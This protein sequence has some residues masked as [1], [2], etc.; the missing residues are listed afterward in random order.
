VPSLLEPNP[1]GQ[2]LEQLRTSGAPLLDLTEMNPTR[3]GL[4]DHAAVADVLRQV[5]EDPRATRY[6]PDPRGLPSARR[7][8]AEY[9]G[10]AVDS[11]RI[12][13]TT[14]TS[15]SYAHLFRLLADPG[16]TV[17]IP[18]PSYPLFDPIAAAEG[19][20]TASYRLE[21]QDGDWAPNVRSIEEACARHDP[22]AL[23][24]VQPNI[25]TGSALSASALHSLD[26]LG[27]ERGLA[28][29]SDEVFADFPWPPQ[30]ERFASLL[31]PRTAPTFVL[32][33]LSKCCGLP[34]LKLGWIA[35]CGPEEPTRELL[36]GLEWMADLFLSVATPVQLALPALLETRHGF[37]RRVAERLA[38]NLATLGDCT[39][40]SE[41][42]LLE[43]RG[44]WAAIVTLPAR[45]TGEEWALALL[46]REVVAHPDHFY[47]LE[48]PS[49]VVSLI[50]EPQTFRTG[51]Q[52]LV[53]LTAEP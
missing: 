38:T 19:V 33:G 37:Q 29:I 15:E 13:L 26:A 41:A 53:G 9:C 40:G 1:W 12:L 20:A 24:I 5:A 23:V 28:L 51:I 39:P 47:D 16:D 52:R 3:L 45:R 46:D 30:N 44:G 27:Q 32:G 50:V 49:V 48:V 21:Y 35:A 36:A 4:V 7:A 14:G 22:R 8:V 34:Q 43:A 31:G 42:R 18:S 25:P 2:R 11:D 6:E 10:G 17:L